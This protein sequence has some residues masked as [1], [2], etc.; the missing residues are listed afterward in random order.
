MAGY[1]KKFTGNK[2]TLYEKITNTIVERI[3]KGNRPFPTVKRKP[4]SIFKQSNLSSFRPYSGVNTFL[5]ELPLFSKPDYLDKAIEKYGNDIGASLSRKYVTGNQVIK[6]FPEGALKGKKSDTFIVIPGSKFYVDSNNKLWK[7]SDKNRKSPTKEEIERLGLVEK[8]GQSRQM[9]MFNV[10]QFID[11]GIP[12]KYI[13]HIKKSIDKLIDNPIKHMENT[14]IVNDLKESLGIKI[15]DEEMSGSAEGYFRFNDNSVHLKPISTYEDQ[16]HYLSTLFHEIT[17]FTGIESI[18]NRSTLRDY[19]KG[20][21]IRAEEELVAELGAAF[22]CGYFGIENK[23]MGHEAYLSH[24]LRSL[25]DDPKISTKVIAEAQ[26]STNFIVEKYENHIQNKYGF[27][28]KKEVES[29]LFNEEENNTPS[30]S[31]EKTKSLDI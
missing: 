24:W 8:R 25:K 15:I 16:D 19:G 2:E 23:N 9:A 31:K 28:S 29:V 3:E 17:H 26:K 14:A 20:Q 10:C 6:E 1:K 5:T 27:D 18:N 12:D 30:K 4:G 11:D 7:S 13:N 21:E 22:L